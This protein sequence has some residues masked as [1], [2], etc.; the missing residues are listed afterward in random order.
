MQ[1]KIA[2]I[3]KGIHVQIYPIAACCHD[4]KTVANLKEVYVKLLDLNYLFI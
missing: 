4:W 2:S 3:K 1:L